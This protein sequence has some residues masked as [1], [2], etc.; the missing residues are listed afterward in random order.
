MKSLRHK[1]ESD[2]KRGI[3]RWENE[4]GRLPSVGL[5]DVPSARDENDWAFH[6]LC[7]S[8]PIPALSGPAHMN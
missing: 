1:I 3:E 4:G 5:G 2:I 8:K 6:V 7:A